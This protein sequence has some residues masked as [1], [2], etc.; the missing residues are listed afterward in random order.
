MPGWTL[1]VDLP[2]TNGLGGLLRALDEV[3]LA[4]GG[5]VY[6]AK[7]ARLDPDAFAKMYPRLPEFEA[8]RRR[9]DPGGVFRSD[10]SRRLNLGGQR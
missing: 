3:V 1:A 8:V 4:A 6:L 10:L 7:D 2:V 5:R 9:A